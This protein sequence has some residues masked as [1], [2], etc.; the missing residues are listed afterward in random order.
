MGATLRTLSPDVRP[1]AQ[2]FV[3]A[4]TRAGVSVT[5]TSARRDPD[6]QRALYE[7]CQRTKCPYPVAPPGHS[8]HALGWAFDLHLDPPVYTEAGE[9]WE[10]LGFTW[11]GR[12]A[13]RVHF[14][15]RPHA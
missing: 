6:Q 11:G 3:R 13:D 7:K 1:I 15:V 9:L 12:F 5:V 10:S 2:A 4:L 14:D 8:T